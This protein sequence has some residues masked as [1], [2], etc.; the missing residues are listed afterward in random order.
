MRPA[1]FGSERLSIIDLDEAGD[2]IDPGTGAPVDP[3]NVTRFLSR[4]LDVADATDIVVF[5]HGWRTSRARAS[6]NAA[7]MFELLA[8]QYQAGHDRYPGLAAWRPYGVVVRW[9]STSG[10]FL[11]GY[12]RIRDRAH[13]MATTG[14][15]TTVL[16]RLLGYLNDRRTP[17]GT[18]PTLQT[19]GG[20]YLHCV[21]H[22]FGGR[23][24]IEAVQAAANERPTLLGWSRSTPGYPY[25]V[26]SLV[27]FQ[28]AASPAIFHDRFARILT[29][30]PIKGP[31]TLT[32][33]RADRATG[34]W[35]RLAENT[36]GIG[37]AG[38]ADVAGAR[39]VALH[40]TDVRYALSELDAVLVNVDANAY[41]RK[42]GLRPEGA[43]S[44]IWRPESAHLVL[45]LAAHSR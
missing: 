43:H 39:S 28:M 21:A 14:H 5:V 9:P 34:I 40:A 42:R 11:R 7:R 3:S 13:A 30:A 26:D 33:S 23:L 45:S 19:A 1:S 17:P 12:R 15:A 20:Q 4:H 22:S 29:N 8:R 38:V 6:T 31:V 36:P 2:L 32:H 18:P 41:F 37:Y 24:I 35:H 27:V 16:S 44:D 10:P 25:T